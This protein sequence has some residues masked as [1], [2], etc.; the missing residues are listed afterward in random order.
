MDLPDIDFGE[1]EKM[2]SS[3]SEKDIDMLSSM[4]QQFFSSEKGEGKERKEQGKNHRANTE[5]FSLDPEM[6]GK[7]MSLLNKLNS[8]T[9]DSRCQFLMSLKP[10]LSKSRQQKVETAISMLRIMSVLPLLNEQGL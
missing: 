2:V 10:M 1:I 4:A 5:G 3:L 8:H 9:D 6:L 7:I